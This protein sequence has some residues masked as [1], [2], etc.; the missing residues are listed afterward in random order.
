MVLECFERFEPE[1]YLRQLFEC[2]E[3]GTSPRKVV[4]AVKEHF[5]LTKSRTDYLTLEELQE[6]IS[7]G[8][9]PI[10]F[11]DLIGQGMQNAHAV[12]VTE[13]DEN[14]VYVVDPDYEE[15]TGMRT[16]ELIEFVR[17]WMGNYG[18]G[19]RTILLE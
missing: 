15:N 16:F 4:E 10:V 5:G 19:G 1:A 18:R 9:C 13:I 12:I 3:S 11:L 6:E 7:C 17:V 8:L 2:D 14:Y